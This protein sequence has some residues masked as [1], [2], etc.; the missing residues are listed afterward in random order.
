MSP[1]FL[2]AGQ[3]TGLSE[4]QRALCEQFVYIPQFGRGTASL[5]VA[6]AASIIMHRLH[7]QIQTQRQDVPKDDTQS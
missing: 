7:A 4:R 5:N 2:L 6:V 3:G 1:H